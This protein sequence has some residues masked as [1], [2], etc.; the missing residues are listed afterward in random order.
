MPYGPHCFGSSWMWIMPVVCLVVMALVAVIVF[1]VLRH[2]CCGR[3]EGFRPPQDAPES[4]LDI[5]KKRYA[6]G[7]IT[8]EQFEQIKRD[9]QE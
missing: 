9:L 7:E 5:L 2:G 8:K 1:F 6:S 4:A 3:Y